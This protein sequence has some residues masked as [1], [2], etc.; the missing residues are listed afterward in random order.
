MTAAVS[1]VVVDRPPVFPQSPYVFDLA[2][3]ALPSHLSD[4]RA[5]NSSGRPLA[6]QGDRLLGARTAVRGPGPAHA[7]ARYAPLRNTFPP[8]RLDCDHAGTCCGTDT[9]ESAPSGT[10]RFSM[11]FASYAAPADSACRTSSMSIE[12]LTIAYRDAA[13]L[14]QLIPRQTEITAADLGLRAK[15]PRAYCPRIHTWPPPSRRA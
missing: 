4:A 11:F 10:A 13:R 8:R 12:S 14:E 7:V 5:S 9:N 1:G 15:L 3:R 6:V 2:P